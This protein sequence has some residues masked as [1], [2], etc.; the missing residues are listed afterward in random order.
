MWTFCLA[1]FTRC[2]RFT[3]VIAWI[4]TSFIFMMTTEHF[5]VFKVL[6]RTDMKIFH[7]LIEFT[8][9]V[10]PFLVQHFKGYHVLIYSYFHTRLWPCWSLSTSWLQPGAQSLWSSPWGFVL[11]K[12]F[13]SHASWKNIHV[14]PLIWPQQ[15]VLAFENKNQEENNSYT[16]LKM[17]LWRLDGLS[18]KYVILFQSYYIGSVN[19]SYYSI[20]LEYIYK[21]IFL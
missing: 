3:H 8:K 16:Y 2:S 17:F 10:Y 13:F 9:Y 12:S 7:V 15:W 14:S 20:I 21:L 18:F 4:S 1:C 6:L 19:T 5:Y 11:E